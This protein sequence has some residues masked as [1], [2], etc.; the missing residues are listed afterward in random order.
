MSMSM[1]GEIYDAVAGGVGAVTNLIGD[2]TVR[3]VASQAKQLGE[4]MIAGQDHPTRRAA[5]SEES[6]TLQQS[7]ST[8]R[9]QS[10]R[11]VVP[12]GRLRDN[13]I[14]FFLIKRAKKCD[15][16][17]SEEAHKKNKWCADFYLRLLITL[18]YQSAITSRANLFDLLKKYRPT[19]HFR[20]TGETEQPQYWSAI[21]DLQENDIGFR[22]PEDQKHSG[23]C[24][25]VLEELEVF[26]QPPYPDYSDMWLSPPLSYPMETASSTRV[27]SAAVTTRLSQSLLPSPQVVSLVI[28]ADHS[29]AQQ[30]PMTEDG[31]FYAPSSAPDL[32]TTS[33]PSPVD[34]AKKRKEKINE[35]VK[36][37]LVIRLIQ[38]EIDRYNVQASTGM[39]A[40]AA[41]IMVKLSYYKNHLIEQFEKDP[42]QEGVD[43]IQDHSDCANELKTALAKRRYFG[44]FQVG[45]RS[46]EGNIVAGK[47]A[48]AYLNVVL[49]LAKSS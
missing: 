39:K 36:N 46:A 4:K 35:C 40:K 38:Q 3:A 20:S 11:G 33:P 32:S 21:P 47:A 25:Y 37:L 19:S 12:V 49:G 45:L 10:Q 30:S 6:T 42:N 28:D 29:L 13:A 5:P 14:K 44:L 24:K 7:N 41:D 1:L 16:F 9:H 17:E 27:D 43:F 26:L 2:P 31:R 48:T 23:F 15:W 8:P 34:E 22:S 18:S